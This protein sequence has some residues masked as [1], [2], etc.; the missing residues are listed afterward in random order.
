MS[1]HHKR[2]VHHRRRALVAT[3]LQ[4]VPIGPPKKYFY[5]VSPLAGMSLCEAGSNP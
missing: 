3:A 5:R 2:I 1:A 4:F